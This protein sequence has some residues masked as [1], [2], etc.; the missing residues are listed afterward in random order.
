MPHNV[1]DIPYNG[2]TYRIY[3]RSPQRRNRH[4][5]LTIDA[6]GKIYLSRPQKTQREDVLRF[7]TKHLTWIATRAKSQEAFTEQ[8]SPYEIDSTHWVLGI[9]YRLFL[10]RTADSKIRTEGDALITSPADEKILA[11]RFRRFHQEESAR[12]FPAL[13]AEQQKY[14]PWVLTMPPLRYRIMHSS[15]GNCRHNGVL[16]FNSRLIQYPAPLIAHVIIHEL[17]H[18]QEHNHSAAFYALMQQAQPDWRERKQELE[19]FRR[20]HHTLM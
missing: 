14:C 3:C 20:T 1:L 17:C 18:L 11:T 8:P 13:V 16:T 12:H 9:P 15:W 6:A 7:I 4:L 10:D 2:Q 5:R 19:A